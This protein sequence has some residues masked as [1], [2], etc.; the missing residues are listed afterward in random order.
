[1]NHFIAQSRRLFIF[2]NKFS[3]PRLSPSIVAVNSKKIVL[4]R[5]LTVRGDLYEYLPQNE[6]G[7]L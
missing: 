5:H 3:T 6:Q 4:H 2:S 7:P 1:M